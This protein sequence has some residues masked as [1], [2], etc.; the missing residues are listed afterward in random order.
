MM[1]EQWLIE[2]VKGIGRFF[3]NPLFYWSIFLIFIV[4]YIRIQRERKYFGFKVFDVFTEWKNT[5]VI[6]IVIGLIISMIMLGIGFVF[7][8]EIILLL[9]IVM[10]ILSLTFKL[11]LLSASY[12]I[13]IT[14][15]L[16]LLS[17][18]LLKYQT[19]LN[20]DIFSEVNFTGII[21][22]MGIFLIVEGIMLRRI[23]REETLPML[24]LGNRGFWIGQHHLKKLSVIPFLVLVPTGLITPFASF[25]P[26]FS[27][28]GESY[29]LVLIPFLIG[30]DYVVQGS[31]PQEA[32]KKLAKSFYVLG[33]IIILIGIGS[34]FISWLS[35]TAVLIAIIGREFINY[36]HR[37][38]DKNNI[39]YFSQVASGLK[40]LSVIPGTPGYRLGILAGETIVKVNNQEINNTEDFYVSLQESGAYFKIAILDDANEVRFVQGALYEGDHH[41]LGLIFT[42]TPHHMKS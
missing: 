38:E 36:K 25:W 1:V 2:I 32:A 4:G 11:T 22:L 27:I 18:L 9:S 21:I 31:L 5:W 35:I 34:I 10:I 16:L 29:S 41:K 40:V 39:A 17:P 33:L 24:T 19:Y 42:E 3:L 37:T 7:S 12:T 15:I 26:Y 13:G 20:I 30:F 28:G 23:K 14:Y 8:Y 6:S